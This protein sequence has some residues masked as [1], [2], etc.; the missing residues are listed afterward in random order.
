MNDDIKITSWETLEGTEYGRSYRRTTTKAPDTGKH[1][2]YG[3]AGFVVGD[4]TVVCHECFGNED[5]DTDTEP[6]LIVGNDEWDYPGATCEDCQRHLDTYLI[7][8]KSQDPKL[9]YR[10]EQH[11]SLG[12]SVSDDLATLEQI[13][14]KAEREAYELG[15]QEAEPI[16]FAVSL[17][18]LG[19]ENREQAAEE[20]PELLETPTDSARYANTIAPKLRAITGYHD[21]GHGTYQ[22]AY[23]DTATFILNEGVHPAYRRGYADARLGRDPNPED[24]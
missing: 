10:L 21:S 12:F 13:A 1:V 23:F 19:A 11:E 9:F 14:D 6:S 22:E 4:C 5:T 18:E 24:C 20:N 16:G 3:C 7:V 2:P 17:E 15:Y 8:N